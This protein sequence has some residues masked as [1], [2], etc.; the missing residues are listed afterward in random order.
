MKILILGSG[1]REHAF[2]WKLSQSAQNPEIFVAP[3]NGG[4]Q[5]L[6]TNVALDITD[7]SAIGHFVKTEGVELVLVGPEAPLVEG[8][9]DYFESDFELKDV[10]LVGPGKLGAQLEGSKDFAKKFMQRYG[11]PTAP[12]RTFSQTETI[13]AQAYLRTIPAPYVLKADGLAAGKGVVILTNLEDALCEIKS[14]LEG[15]KFGLASER[16]VIEGFLDGIECS[17]FALTDGEHYVLLPE[18]KDYKRIGEG[19]T[20]LNTGGMGAISPVV[21]ADSAF[22]AKVVGRIVKPTIAGLKAD[23]IS[24]RGFIFFGLI[25]VGDD[26]YVIEY[27]VRM[28]DPE[29]EAVLPRIEDDLLDLLQACAKD[30]LAGKQPNFLRNASATVVIVS[31]GYPGDYRKSKAIH[32]SEGLDEGLIFHS[33]TTKKEDEILTSGGRVLAVT[34]TGFTAQE[35]LRQVYAAVGKVSFEGANYRKDIGQDLLK[36]ESFRD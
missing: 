11:I 19:D 21:F 1:G 4:T 32:F 30:S 29:T 17:V 6:A 27:N 22:M 31:E 34:G 15:A 10:G 16:V 36:M 13:E 33:G 5:S 14:M 26:P 12:Y 23:G 20:G 9:R 7:F 18:A 8:I 28:G 25:K 3:G 2:A 24:Y 35:A